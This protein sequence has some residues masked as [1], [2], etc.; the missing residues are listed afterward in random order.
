MREQEILITTGSPAPE[1]TLPDLTG[2]RHSLADYRGGVV[3]LNF[4]S[5]EC[6]WSERAD[7]IIKPRLT[8]L[9]PAMSLL[10]IASNANEPVDEIR[11][12][13]AARNVSPV[14]LDSDQSVA[15]LYQAKTT[16]HYFVIDARGVLR[17]QGA[18]DDATFRQREVTQEYLIEALEALMAG[19]TPD[20]EQSLPYGC[21]L[22]R[23]GS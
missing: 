10:S 8:A 19:R 7:K 21:A 20:P 3:V 12:A 2:E 6:P 11:K 22:V 18:P 1:F 9:K 15:N 23:Y 14:L 16:P 13:A 17:Y 5:A 4:W